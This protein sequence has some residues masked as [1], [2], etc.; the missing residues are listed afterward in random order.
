MCIRDR[1][2]PGFFHWI[3]AESDTYRLFDLIY[4]AF[5]Y[6]M[7]LYIGYSASKKLKTSIPLGLLLG[8]ILL[9]PDYIALV[10]ACLLYTSRCV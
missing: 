5:F 4:N 3:S 7:P 8:G 10:S 9:V 6:F 1:I 2:G